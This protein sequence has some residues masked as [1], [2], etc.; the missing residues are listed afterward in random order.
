MEWV[1]TTADSVDAAKELALDQ[2]GVASDEAEFEIIEEPKSGLF[3]RVRGEA[4][5]RARIRP[6]AARPRQERRGKSRSKSATAG[7]SDDQ[8]QAGGTTGSTGEAIAAQGPSKSATSKENRNPA[9][10]PPRTPRPKETTVSQDQNQEP[11]AT[12]QQVGEAAEGFL[13]GLAA[14]MGVEATTSLMIDGIEIEVRMDGEG[15]GLLVG[16]GGNTLQALQDITRV[17]A[18]RRLGDH[19]TRLKIDIAGYRQRRQAALEK[20]TR[21]VADQVVSSVTSKAMEPMT[22]ADRKVVHDTVATISGV[23]SHSEGD[24]PSRRVVI[25]LA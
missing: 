14:A 20:F 1:E 8:T 10:R 23:V 13:I 7:G 5:V 6:T 16:P 3:G 21:A 9:A 25:T 17:A 2:L 24:D 19:E 4:R 18:Q 11:S 12:P 22:A 15:L